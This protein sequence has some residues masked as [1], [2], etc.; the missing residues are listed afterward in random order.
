MSMGV[1]TGWVRQLDL[2]M[3]DVRVRQANDANSVLVYEGHAAKATRTV[4]ALAM[5]ANAPVRF[6]LAEGR[7]VWAEVALAAESG[8]NA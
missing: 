6:R 4:L 1:L 8:D 3:G 7:L 2:N 5:K